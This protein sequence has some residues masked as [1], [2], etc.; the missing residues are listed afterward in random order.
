MRRR[1]ETEEKKRETRSPVQLGQR[2]LAAR[3][4]WQREGGQG[5]G[6][7]AIGCHVAVIRRQACVGYAPCRSKYA[8]IVFGMHY[9]MAVGRRMGLDIHAFAFILPR[10]N[11]RRMQMRG[12]P[13]DISKDGSQPPW[14]WAGAP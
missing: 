12:L 11:G 4:Q 13:S 3:L 1:R 10:L 8:H 2:S 9:R 14:R 6:S 5:V 7:M